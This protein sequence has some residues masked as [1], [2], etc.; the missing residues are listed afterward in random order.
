MASEVDVLDG[1]VGPLH[2]GH[3][4]EHQNHTGHTENDKENKRH[5]TEVERVGKGKALDFLGNKYGIKSEEM[6]A[7]GDSFND[8]NSDE[9][10]VHTVT[11]SSFRMSK[12][13][14]TN[15]QYVEFLNDAFDKGEI[16]V[17]GGIVYAVTE[18]LEGNDLRDR[19]RGSMLP[20]SKAIPLRPLPL[21]A[22][23]S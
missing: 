20:L 13:E 2:R 18:L 1:P 7:M 11:L 15:G 22:G 5:G 17:D 16:R 6:I 4:Q 9:R 12:Y 10:P 23:N 19:L 8:G 21:I 3:I 14:I